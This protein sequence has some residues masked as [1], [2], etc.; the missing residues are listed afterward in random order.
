MTRSR[1]RS[2]L[3]ELMKEAGKHM[4]SRRATLMADAWC[5]GMLNGIEGAGYDK[6]TLSEEHN[7]D[8][9]WKYL[10]RAGY[11][12]TRPEVQWVIHE[13]IRRGTLLV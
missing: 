5:T 7:V 3:L 8:R 10:T 13:Y 12:V 1:G 6:T 2:L 9:L 11:P 4:A